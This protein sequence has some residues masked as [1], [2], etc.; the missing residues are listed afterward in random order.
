MDEFLMDR[1]RE[2]REIRERT[3]NIVRMMER[4]FIADE[5]RAEAVYAD[6]MVAAKLR[7]AEQAYNDF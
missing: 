1:V 6:D 2:L 7:A 3:Q 5:L 4:Y